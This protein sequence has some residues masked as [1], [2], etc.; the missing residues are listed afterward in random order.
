[1]DTPRSAGASLA[2]RQAQCRGRR[3][4]IKPVLGKNGGAHTGLNPGASGRITRASGYEPF[5]EQDMRLVMMP[6]LLALAACASGDASTPSD[7]GAGHVPAPDASVA[8]RLDTILR[9]HRIATAGF[10][11]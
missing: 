8:P 4:A 6:V 7:G 1:A 2:V 5:L 10:G 11:V 9:E 3:L